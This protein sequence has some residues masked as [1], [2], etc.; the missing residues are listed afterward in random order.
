M[1]EIKITPGDMEA[2][3]GEYLQK[4]EELTMIKDTLTHFIADLREQWSGEATEAFDQQWNDLKP[5]F[6]QTEE[7]VEQI[8]AQL[9]STAAAMSELDSSIAGQMGVK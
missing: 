7:F 8:A 9:K 3:A 6:D 2:K 5:S 4:K 1:S